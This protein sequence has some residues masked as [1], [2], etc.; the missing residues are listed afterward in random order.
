MTD[1]RERDITQAF[2]SLASHLA[3]GYDVVDLLND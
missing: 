3:N 1:S 2:V